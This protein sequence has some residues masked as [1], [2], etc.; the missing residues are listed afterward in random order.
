MAAPYNVSMS[1]LY[2]ADADSRQAVTVTLARELALRADVSFAFAYGS[3][4]SGLDGFRDIDVAV[5]LKPDGDRF[6]D[7]SL[8]TDLSRTV[9]FP[10][11][12][13]IANAA[14]VSFLFHVLRGRL[15]SA[16]DESLL[17]DVMERTA[18]QYHDQAPLVHMATRDAFAA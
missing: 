3:F 10:V 6:A 12:V 18:R 4:V 15:L 14:P 11:D 17:A 9:D 5:W 16:R 1:R 2:R 13:R 7:L 8:A